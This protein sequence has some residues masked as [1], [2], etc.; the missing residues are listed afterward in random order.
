M[1]GRPKAEIVLTEEEEAA[2][3]RWRR[4]WRT[5]R[6]LSMRAQIILHAARGMDGCDIANELQV[7]EA[8]VC[9]WRGRF[10]KNRLG[11]LSD[12]PR[13]G[14]PRTILDEEVQRVV[15]KTLSSKPKAATHWSSRSMAKETGLSQSAIIR[16]WHTFGLQ[17][18][19]HETFKLSQD[20]NF[21]EKVKDI[22]GLYM[23]PPTRAV[24][25][26]VDEKS[27][28]QA[29][30]RTQPLLPLR[31]GQAERG[32]HDYKRH[33]T[34]S[35][36][37]ALNAK[38]GEVYGTCRMRHRSQ[39]FLKFLKL[40]DATVPRA[41]GEEIHL[42][43]DN[44][45]THKTAAVKRWLL[46]HPEYHLHFTPTSASWTNLVERFFAEITEKAIRRGVF[47][48]VQNLEETIKLY[49]DDWNKNPKPFVWTAPADLILKRVRNVISRTSNSGH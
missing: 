22:V 5:D 2:L 44:Y 31:P 14:A 4:G 24:V 45:A 16:I 43:L 26:C 8:T 48:S 6:G 30:D 40:L 28:I 35:L 19:R 38:T 11:G 32:T 41:P 47:K 21:V 46:R 27:Q 42:I 34:L 25:L 9:K 18:H 49:L 3:T 10:V 39:E 13:S 23:N 36:F 37:A 7:H 33:G 12:A 29:L 20:P 1:L 17:P 15:R